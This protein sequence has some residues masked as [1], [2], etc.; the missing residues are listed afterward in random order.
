[1]SGRR[2]PK[3]RNAI[4]LTGALALRRL[5]TI[6]NSVVPLGLRKLVAPMSAATELNRLLL[7]TREFSRVRL[8]LL[9]HSL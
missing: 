9:S 6:R 8:V 4:G 1:M 7:S 5:T 3:L 2:G